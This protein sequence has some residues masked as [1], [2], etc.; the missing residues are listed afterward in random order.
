[1]EYL[2]LLMNHSLRKSFPNPHECLFGPICY[3]LSSLIEG[4]APLSWGFRDISLL[5][6]RSLLDEASDFNLA[7]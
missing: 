6:L 1:M 5:A 3:Y 4:V 7:A 2:T